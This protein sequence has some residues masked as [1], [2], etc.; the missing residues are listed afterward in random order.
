MIERILELLEDSER[1]AAL[2]RMARNS[3]RDFEL[4]ACIE[5]FVGSF[6]PIEA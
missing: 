6:L 2:S 4:N 5:R 1:R 3:A